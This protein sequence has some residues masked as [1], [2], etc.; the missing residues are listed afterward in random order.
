MFPRGEEDLLIKSNNSG[1]AV[2]D[3]P[4]PQE[5]PP[6]VSANTEED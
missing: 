3:T 5:E 6:P 4:G 1:Y 2:T